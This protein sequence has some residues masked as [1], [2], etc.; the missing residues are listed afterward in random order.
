[1]GVRRRCALMAV[2]V[3]VLLGGAACGDD[4]PASPPVAWPPV[5][6]VTLGVMAD[7]VVVV[8]P[9]GSTST[10]MF[11]TIEGD[12]VAEVESVVGDP[13]EKGLAPACSPTAQFVTFP[14]ITVSLLDGIFVGWTLRPDAAGGDHHQRRDRPGLHP[15]RAR[16]VVR[17]RHRR[18]DVDPRRRV[19]RRRR[20]VRHPRRHRTRCPGRRPLGRGHLRQRV[21]QKPGRRHSRPGPDLSSPGRCRGRGL[22]GRLHGATPGSR[23]WP[24]GRSHRWRRGSCVARRSSGTSIATSL[25]AAAATLARATRPA[26]RAARRRAS[27][28]TRA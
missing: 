16:G 28:H 22:R 6:E 19:R 21:K 7:G 25:A 12:V 18:S 8:Q 2:V 26:G 24:V 11:G 20:G 15:G 17:R 1:M 14:G 4:E 13:V 3:G 9:D 27:V 10:T 5:D 23:C